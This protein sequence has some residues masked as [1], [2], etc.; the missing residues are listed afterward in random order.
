[1]YVRNLGRYREGLEV[2]RRSRLAVCDLYKWDCIAIESIVTAAWMESKKRG[3]HPSDHES[4]LRRTV[5]VYGVLS[6]Y[7]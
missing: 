1:M 7:Y 2:V 4:I 6:L 3:N 5:G